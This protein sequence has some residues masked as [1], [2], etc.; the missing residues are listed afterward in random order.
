MGGSSSPAPAPAP[1]P[2]AG[3]NGPNIN[4]TG[5]TTTPP[6]SSPYQPNY[7]TIGANTGTASGIA[8]IITN[9]VNSG[10]FQNYQTNPYAPQGS[11]NPVN[12]PYGNQQQPMFNMNQVNPYGGRYMQNWNPYG[13]NYQGFN[14]TWNQPQGSNVAPPPNTTGPDALSQLNNMFGQTNQYSPFQNNQTSSVNPLQQATMMQQPQSDLQR[15]I[16][17]A[18]PSNT[19]YAGLDTQQPNQSPFANISAST[20]PVELSPEQQQKQIDLWNSMSPEQ[21]SQAM[22]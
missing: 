22:G 7:G 11:N 13:N 16:T 2:S 14:S 12:I 21:R 5:P 8:G 20:G 6:P 15:L 18:P 3:Y 17:N 9:L 10:A 1:N 19:P 4:M